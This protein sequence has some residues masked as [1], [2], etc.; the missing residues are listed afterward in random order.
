MILRALCSAA[1]LLGAALALPAVAQSAG[2]ELAA[3]GAA[4]AAIPAPVQVVPSSPAVSVIYKL[5]GEKSLRPV[6]VGD[7]GVHM[8]IQ[9]GAEQELPAVFSINPQGGE[10]MVDG[11]MRE[12]VFTIDRVYP[13]L[14]FR[15]DKKSAK[16]VRTIPKRKK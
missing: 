11:F 2:G 13:V 16:A 15:I 9:W 10:E 3:N 6:Q 7:D 14:V 12:G 5:S 4:R 8:Y 1:G